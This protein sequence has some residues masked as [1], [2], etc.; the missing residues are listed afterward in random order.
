ML[1]LIARVAGWISRECEGG[2]LEYAGWIAR[3]FEG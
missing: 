3:E 2:L 1:G